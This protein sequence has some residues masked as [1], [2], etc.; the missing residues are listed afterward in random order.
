MSDVVKAAD[1]D[2]LATEWRDMRTPRPDD[3]QQRY[4]GTPMAEKI[5]PWPSGVAKR[6]FLELFY[7]LETRST[8]SK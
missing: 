1:D 6:E 5:V 3:D 4:G 2:I 8:D 7:V